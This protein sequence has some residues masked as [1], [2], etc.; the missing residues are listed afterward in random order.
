MQ[1]ARAVQDATAL[2]VLRAEIEA[3]DAREGNCG[4]AHRAWFERDVEIAVDQAFGPKQP[5]TLA[6]D[7]DFCVCRRIAELTVAVACCGQHALVPHENRADRHLATARR[8]AR[9]LQ[10]QRHVVAAVIHPQ[11]IRFAASTNGATRSAMTDNDI[12]STSTD[13]EPERDPDRARIAKVIARA[14]IASRR[15]AEVLVREGRVEVNGETVTEPGTSVGPRDRVTID[16]EPL[17]RRERT[18]LW[19]YHKPRGLV[20]T[21]KDPEGRPTV[22]D[23][24]PPELPR[25]ISVGRL[26]LNTEGLLLLTND[27]GLARVLALPETGWLR[28]YRVRAYGEITPDALAKLADGVDIDGFHYAG[29]EAEIDRRQGDNTWLTLGLREGKNR[30]VR[31]V[32]EHL[33]LQVNRLI[34]ISFG[35][36][37]LGDMAEGS[38]EEVRTRY[39][40]DQLGDRLA[41]EAAADFDGPIIERKAQA[42]APRR[43]ESAGEP[44][45][46]AGLIADRRGRRVLVERVEKEAPAPKREDR[47][48]PPR[49]EEERAERPQRAERPEFAQREDRPAGPRAKPARRHGPDRSGGPRPARPKAP[50]RD[51]RG[52]ERAPRQGGEW[53]AA[54]RPARDHEDGGRPQGRGP[55]P[56]GDRSPPRGARPAG[57]RPRPYG[58][59]GKPGFDKK[60]E[61]RPERSDRPRPQ[62]DRPG[63]DRP[64]R[65]NDRPQGERPRQFGTG[66]D[67][68]RGPRGSA[69]RPGGRPAGK[70]SSGGKPGGFGGKPAGGKRPF[71]GGGKPGGP[72]GGRPGGSRPGGSRPGG[73]GRPP[74]G[75][76]PRG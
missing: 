14:G 73:Q 64:Y 61:D 24:L 62:G 44:K 37:Q 65:S 2:G 60:R 9:F 29:I 13:P 74:G 31:R 55:R 66:E 23:M 1:H 70:P 63:G 22:F 47:P 8:P 50:R 12:N 7:Q 30:E 39:L 41:E 38:V 25:V 53:D 57:D 58:T 17:P 76:R 33:G 54:P 42:R 51:E 71:G 75:G 28:R 6:Q 67:A 43:E 49:R 27:G 46:R 32:L 20:T 18:R 52:E 72:G 45:R 36:F 19:L 69:G 34:R 26:D 10:R 11:N 35:P 21:A 40:R 56:Q 15:D 16:G 48:R 68:V 4:R 59:S 3:P 5:S